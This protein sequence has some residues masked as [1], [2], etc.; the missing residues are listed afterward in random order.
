MSFVTAEPSHVKTIDIACEFWTRINRLSS[1]FQATP[2][3]VLQVEA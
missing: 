3:E 1:Q 2:A